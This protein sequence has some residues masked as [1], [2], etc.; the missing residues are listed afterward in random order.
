LSLGPT[1]HKIYAPLE[2][3]FSDGWGPAPILSSNGFRYFVIFVDA[4][5]KFIWFYPRSVKFDVFNVFHQFQV[6]V[7]R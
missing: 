6:L 1:G 5:I 3:I 7:E 2:L 4:H